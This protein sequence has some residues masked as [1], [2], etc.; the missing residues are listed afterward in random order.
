MV[1][2]TM[3]N[4][5]AD[6]SADALST[7]V[8]SGSPAGSE[9]VESEALGQAETRASGGQADLGKK[10]VF[11]RLF[12]QSAAPKIGRFALEGELGR[13]GMGI[14]YAAR[15]P[16]L[17]RTVALLTR[18][19]LCDPGEFA[20][21]V[22]RWKAAKIDAL[23]PTDSP[24]FR[25]AAEAFDRSSDLFFTDEAGLEAIIDRALS[26]AGWRERRSASLAT[27]LA[28]SMGMA[29]FARR[30]LDFVRAGLT[31]G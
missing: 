27:D 15:D 6:E 13:G 24:E 31:A 30:M 1:I 3:G 14:V 12:D 5:E 7:T 21:G 16:Q 23:R 8:G 19:G 22:L 9:R 4:P 20:D 18:L 28:E 26:D 29:S 17:E 11:A 2:W 10:L 25:N